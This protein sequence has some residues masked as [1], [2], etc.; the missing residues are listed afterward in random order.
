MG[1]PGVSTSD[2]LHSAAFRQQR[3]NTCILLDER[4]ALSDTER[5]ARLEA[6]RGRVVDW[7][8]QRPMEFKQARPEPDS[9]ERREDPL[10]SIYA[11][12]RFNLWAWLDVRDAAQSLEK[13]VTAAYD[14]AHALFVNDH[15]NWLN[16]DA[17][18]LSQLFFPEVS[19]SKITLSGS[20]ALVSIDRARSLIGFEPEYSVDKLE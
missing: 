12:D 7:R 1:V 8:K 17:K 18:C 19:E 16:Y 4:G 3:Q 15:R 9:I 6:V 14:G 2:H 20:S 11:L 13:G 10:L 5:Q